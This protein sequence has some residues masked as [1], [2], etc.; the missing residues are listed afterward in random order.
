MLSLSVYYD[1]MTILPTEHYVR[2][3]HDGTVTMCRDFGRSTGCPREQ[4]RFY[5]PP[6]HIQELIRPAGPF[7][8]QVRY[9]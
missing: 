5:H 1:Y 2:R 7:A 4:C 8:P 9:Q 3:N 6:A